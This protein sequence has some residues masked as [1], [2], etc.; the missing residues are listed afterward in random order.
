MCGALRKKGGYLMIIR[1]IEVA[2][3]GRPVA[4]LSFQNG[5]NV[6]AGPSNTGKSYVVDCLKFALGSSEIPK[7]IS[8][9]RGYTEVTVEFELDNG[10]RLVFTRALTA[11][12]PTIVRGRDDEPI[13][14]LK[15]RHQSG[16]S[17]ISN[18]FLEKLGLNDKVLLKG[19]E[20]LTVQA[21]TLRTLEKIF[22][23]DE[24]R[25]VSTN[26][27]L[28]TGQ[29]TEKTLESS[30]LRTLL[31][32]QDD[33]DA[34]SQKAVAKSK[35]QLLARASHLRAAL[36]MLF[37]E[38]SKASEP[39]PKIDHANDYGEQLRL[40]DEALVQKISSN[41]NL[42]DKK[43]E[44]E[45]AIS[46]YKGVQYEDRIMLDQFN[47][48]IEKYESDRSRLGG[49]SQ[50]SVYFESYK[51]QSCP[52]CSQEIA[53]VID[54]EAYERIT[55]GAL[56]EAQKID[57]QIYHLKKTIAE[58]E[59]KII[60][61]RFDILDFEDELQKINEE[62]KINIKGRVAEARREGMVYH[63]QYIEQRERAAKLTLYSNSIKEV[64]RIEAEA[65][66]KNTNYEN[67][68]SSSDVE[69]FENNV[70]SIFER[71]GYLDYHPV[72]YSSVDRDLMIA[73]SPRAHLGKGYRAIT[74]AAFVIALMDTIH[75]SGRH[76][77]FVVL[78]SPLTTFK[79]ADQDRG[80]EDESITKD[81]IYAFYRDLIDSYGDRQIIIF[82]NQE[83]D[84]DLQPMMKYIHFTK[85]EKLG[86]PGFFS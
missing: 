15:G 70:V 22:V 23:V 80:D 68:L 7:K 9:S 40:M 50:A 17:N 63:Q 65:N 29:R 52:A 18:F 56:A 3:P 4:A 71:W 76:P 13:S 34:K 81:M 61:N 54:A 41:K 78:D 44:Y 72:K 33:F 67:K 55:I 26:S 39:I 30:L 32:G 77:G 58:L 25:I 28:G 74:C 47:L 37:P 59:A 6:V 5:L 86:R 83:P 82:D 35:K 79:Q 53:K 14:I 69:K 2:G 48:L 10:E 19:K 60:Q 20:E 27:P 24:S 31:T 46:E 36:L 12:A 43:S 73:E 38:E 11:K 51:S 75:G 8:Q 84:L 16:L 64:D 49:I 66:S 57:N 85:N 21:L 42:F 1:K 45:T 62:I